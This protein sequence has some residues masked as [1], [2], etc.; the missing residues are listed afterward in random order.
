[1]YKEAF[2]KF[3]WGFFF[4][5]FSFRIQK[6]DIVPDIIGYILIYQGLSIL[7]NEEDEFKQSKKFAFPMIFLSIFSIYDFQAPVNSGFGFSPGGWMVVI[8]FLL[9]ILIFIVDLQMIY[10]LFMGIK[11]LA[12][13]GGL[14]EIEDE[15]QKRWNNYKALIIA[16]LVS[17]F[18]IF[19]PFLALIWLIGVL[20]ATIVIMIKIM[21]FMKK[22]GEE[23]V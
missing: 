9:S 21:Q 8:L 2:N 4:V 14:P 18:L 17:I 1:M 19:V 15:A 16:A 11:N 6:F 20:I 22:C 5:M 7:E 3:F 10:H 12:I 13:E 23:F